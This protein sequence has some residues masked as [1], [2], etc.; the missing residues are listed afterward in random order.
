MALIEKINISQIS[1]TKTSLVGDE[2]MVGR[3]LSGNDFKISA[4]NFAGLAVGSVPVGTVV[5]FIGQSL[6]LNHIIGDGSSLNRVTYSD[7]YSII[8][9]EIGTF[10][11]TLA[12]PGV[13]TLNGHGLETSDNVEITTDGTLP[14]GLAEYTNYFIEKIDSDSFYLCPTRADAEASTNRIATSVTQSGV[15]TLRY[16]PYGI[17]TSDNFY[18]PDFQGAFLRGEGTN[19]LESY[20]IGQR[21]GIA[22]LDAMQRITASYFDGTSNLGGRNFENDGSGAITEK[23]TS[24]TKISQSTTY[25]FSEGSDGFDF[26]NADSTSPIQAK[27]DDNETRP[28]NHTVKL[29]IK[30]K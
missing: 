19:A 12:T 23:R 29:I 28:F 1:A 14:T 20:L 4:Q 18:I 17:N 5:P 8:T 25:S 7:L 30:Y 24:A 6:P 21:L 16:T 2:W 9:S 15:H 11:V 13:F 22:K 10:T 27:T 26:D 3:D